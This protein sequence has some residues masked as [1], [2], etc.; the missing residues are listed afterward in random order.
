MRQ[1]AKMINDGHLADFVAERYKS[2]EDGTLPMQDLSKTSFQELETFAM[3]IED[4]G[5]DIQSAQ[6]EKAE[7]LFHFYT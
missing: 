2:F 3:S 6:Q 5:D 7:I 4:P 1:A